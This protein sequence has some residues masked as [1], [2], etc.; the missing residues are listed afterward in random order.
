MIPTSDIYVFIREND[1][2]FRKMVANQCKCLRYPGSPDDVVQDLYIRFLTVCDVIAL[3]D[4][5]RGVLI[6][7][8]L[9]KIIKNFIISCYKGHEGSY[10]RYRTAPVIQEH[11][12][13]DISDD[14]ETYIDHF[15]GNEDY[16]INAYCNNVSNR[17]N[18]LHEDFKDFKRNLLDPAH[19]TRY[20]L[21]RRVR[22]E[23]SENNLKVLNSLKDE[24]MSG[25]ESAE[26]QSLMES[27]EKIGCTLYNLFQLFYKGYTNIQISDIYGIST[28][29]VSVMKTRLAL[30][31][32]QYGIKV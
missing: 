7:S 17:E 10:Y 12:N 1:A 23:V 16:E 6:S 18:P 13:E 30:A 26:I 14:F 5:S 9:F 25:P 21:N 4:E 29:T 22:R 27:V 28:T 19:N 15:K 32:L 31:I 3:Y 11:E 20:S 24:D 8:Y 2:E